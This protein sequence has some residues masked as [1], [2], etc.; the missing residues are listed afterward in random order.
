MLGKRRKNK[1]K[2]GREEMKNNGLKSTGVLLKGLNSEKKKKR[3]E[4]RE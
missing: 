3:L 1:D 4:V 2:R